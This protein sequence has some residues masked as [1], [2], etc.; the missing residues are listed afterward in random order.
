MCMDK[1]WLMIWVCCWIIKIQVLIIKPGKITS[2]WTVRLWILFSNLCKATSV[3][4]QL[5]KRPLVLFLVFSLLVLE[6]TEKI[7]SWRNRHWCLSIACKM[8]AKC[9]RFA[10]TWRIRGSIQPLFIIQWQTTLILI[11]I[12]VPAQTYLVM[13]CAGMLHVR[14]VVSATV[15]QSYRDTVK[16]IQWKRAIVPLY[17][18]IL[19]SSLVLRE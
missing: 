9:L 11:F 18:G 6:I 8:F 16:E 5:K 13:C 4:I 7:L 17:G 2:F 15:K 19:N 12:D 3:P 14:E 1:L 10:V